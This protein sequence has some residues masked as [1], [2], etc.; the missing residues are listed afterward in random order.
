M[1]EHYDDSD[2]RSDDART[3][4]I[5]KEGAHEAV[6]ETFK[7]LGID[8]NEWHEVQK[9]TAFLRKLRTNCDSMVTWVARVA[10]AV[11]FSFIVAVVAAA[12]K[13]KFWK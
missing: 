4:Q 13:F 6:N 5:A 10:A 7:R 8:T 12:F 1:T 11:V 2:K 3:K 9:D